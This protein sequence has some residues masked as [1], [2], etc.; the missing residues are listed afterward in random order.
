MELCCAVVGFGSGSAGGSRLH[1]DG[2]P[3]RIEGARDR[4]CNAESMGAL[5][6]CDGILEVAGDV[7][8]IQGSILEVGC[9]SADC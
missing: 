3:W 2:R 4:V 8:V 5:E 6:G 1:Q 7:R 9:G